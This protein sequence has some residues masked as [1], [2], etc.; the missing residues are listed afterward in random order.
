MRRA[1]ALYALV[2]LA[3]CGG[4]D[5]NSSSSAE[6][7]RE[8][9]AFASNRDGDFE[10]YT[11]SS[12]G[13]GVRQLTKN[14]STPESERD[15]NEPK[16]SRDGRWIAFTSTRDYEGDGAEHHELY[17]MGADGSGQRR[18]T[19]N[20]T[21]ELVSGWTADGEIVFWRCR[22][23]IARCT[24]LV[25][26]RDGSD[27]RLV[28]ETDQVLLGT[29][30]PDDNGDVRAAI[31]ELDAPTMEFGDSVIIDLEFG[32]GRPGEEGQPPPDGKGLLIETDRDS[33]GRCLFH[34][35][36]GDATELYNG[37][38]RLTRTKGEETHAVWSPDGT[39]ILFARIE[40][41]EDDYELWVMNADGTCPTQ[42][43]D[44]GDWDWM[45]DWV[46]PRQGPGPL[47]C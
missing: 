23:G 18:L 20:G 34:D 45:P 15:D 24:L 40:N 21:A 13:S 11:M 1:C 42:L 33:N 17:V 22:E 30:G 2:L 3:G 14:E 29:W 39:R 25:V 41:E 5:D 12:D 37:G 47:T 10:I 6:P 28:Y 43:T 9:I 36:E 46:G 31:T 32:G 7:A 19:E 16:W 8:A 44:N 35:C 4:S 27:E 26:E 38:R